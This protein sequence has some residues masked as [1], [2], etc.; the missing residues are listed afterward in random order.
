MNGLI[1][2]FQSLAAAVANDYIIWNAAADLLY[3]RGE[4]NFPRAGQGLKAGGDVDSVAVVIFIYGMHVP[5]G[6]TNFPMTCLVFH[7]NLMPT[8]QTLLSRDCRRQSRFTIF[9]SGQHKVARLLQDTTPM[10]TNA[11]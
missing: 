9:K 2:V 6:D 1:N 8:K 4:A 7:A 5:I 3:R 11:I 10:P